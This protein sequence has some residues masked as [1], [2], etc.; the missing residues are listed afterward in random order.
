MRKALGAGRGRDWRLVQDIQPLGILGTNICTRKVALHYG[1]QCMG[2]RLAP[3]ALVK[4]GLST[5]A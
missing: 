5:L 1:N 2:V 4:L 3:D